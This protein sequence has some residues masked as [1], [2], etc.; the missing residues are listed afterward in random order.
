MQSITQKT[1]D[2]AVRAPI[3]IGV[4]LRRSGSS[5]YSPCNNRRDTAKRHE[6]HVILKSCWIQNNTIQIFYC[7][8]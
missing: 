5:S 3:K 4:E 1:K 2:L 8:S 6:H 7:Q